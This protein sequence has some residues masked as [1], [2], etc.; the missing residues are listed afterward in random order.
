MKRDRELLFVY[1]A[2]KFSILTL[3]KKLKKKKNEVEF[4]F[5]YFG[6]GLKNGTEIRTK[7][8]LFLYF[9]ITLQFLPLRV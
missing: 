4:F 6:G 5:F 3:Y 8:F 2:R 1:M 7:L 9:F